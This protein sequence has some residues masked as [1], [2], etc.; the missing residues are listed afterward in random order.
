MRHVK[1]R[2]KKSSGEWVVG[3]LII[4]NNN[5]NHAIVQQMSG[6]VKKGVIQGWCFGVLPETVGEFSGIE[7]INGIEIYEGDLLLDRAYDQEA[8]NG[9]YYECKLPIFFENGAFWVDESFKKDRSTACLL[10][11]WEKPIVCGNVWGEIILY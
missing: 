10:A 4:D 5:G 8:P 9:E 1:Y 6:P 7:D 11:E 3:S 2:G